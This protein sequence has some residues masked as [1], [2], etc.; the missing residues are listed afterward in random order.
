MDFD[1]NNYFES[2]QETLPHLLLAVVILFVGWR[3]V[4][5]LTRK[6]T[7][8]LQQREMDPAVSSFITSL[9]S[10]LLKVLVIFSAAEMIGIETASFV[11]ILAAASFAIGMAMQGSL[12]NFASGVMILIFKP[13]RVGDIIELSEMKGHVTEIQIFNT[14]IRTPKNETV[15]IPNS[16]VMSDKIVNH[17]AVGNVRVDIIFHMPYEEQFERVQGVVQEVLRSHTLVLEDPSPLVAIES[18]E[19][20]NI[21]VG[22]FA[23]C[24]PDDY[25]KVYYELNNAIKVALGKHNVNVA[26][27]EGIE[28]GKIGDR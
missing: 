8:V 26:Y 25:W 18:Y 24:R 4:G 19:S 2:F 28:L 14:I 10:I 11:A 21:N 6:L 23:F 22:V 27:S 1:F 15:I 13:F 5:W 20:H 16:S 3:V 17:S 12:S 9:L 7:T